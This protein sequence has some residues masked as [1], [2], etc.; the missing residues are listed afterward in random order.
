MA[1]RAHATTPAH[2]HRIFSAAPPAPASTAVAK[3]LPCRSRETRRSR[4]QCHATCSNCSFPSLSSRRRHAEPARRALPV[5]WHSRARERRRGVAACFERGKH[6][7]GGASGRPARR[8]APQLRAAPACSPRAAGS[9][10][11]ACGGPR[12]WSPPRRATGRT[13]H[14]AAAHS[15]RISPSASWTV[16]LLWGPRTAS[17]L[18]M[19]ES[20]ENVAIGAPRCALPSLLTQAAHCGAMLRAPGRPCGVA[21]PHNAS[22]EAR[23]WRRA[24]HC[25]DGPSSASTLRPFAALLAPGATSGQPSCC[26]HGAAAPGPEQGSAPREAGRQGA[27]G[28]LAPLCATCT[29]S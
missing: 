23:D 8:R 4:F 16:R 21:D 19:M 3:T 22:R 13:T 6:R 24:G 5:G 10:G 15:A 17:S 9:A 25:F 29:G 26:D 27:L 2:T 7:V 28:A 14:R 12:R 11:A 1:L 18:S 20:T